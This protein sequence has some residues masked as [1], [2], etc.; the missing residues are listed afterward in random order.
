MQGR[1]WICQWEDKN[2][3]FRA[4]VRE[5][6]GIV[7][8]ADSFE[9]VDEQLWLAIGKASGDV[10]N[11]REYEPAGTKA[12]LDLAELVRA[13]LMML[14]PAGALRPKNRSALYSRGVCA[15]CDSPLGR[16][17][18][19]AASV[20]VRRTGHI[21][22]IDGRTVLS[23]A[24]FNLLTPPERRRFSWRALAGAAHAYRELAASDCHATLQWVRN[25][26]EPGGWRCGT[27][28][29]RSDAYHTLTFA[30]SWF[31]S[32]ADVPE[33]R[34]SVM[35]VGGRHS[36]RLTLRGDRWKT[37]RAKMGSGA[38]AFEV[39]VMPPSTLLKRPALPL[40]ADLRP[41]DRIV[42]Q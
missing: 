42:P 33:T 12:P 41:R 19:E 29:Q 30:P 2:G 5:R 8:N 3:R 9:D 24:A 14:H 35:T 4:W 25:A 23:E 6:P 13:K 17:T 28:G 18:K 16:R 27:C 11:K 37:F 36:L 32:A 26:R 22:S 31:V 21:F 38:G 39:D 1:I 10:D 40:Y 15:E 7:A 20:A 34:P